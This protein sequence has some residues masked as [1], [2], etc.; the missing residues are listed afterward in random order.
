MTDYIIAVCKYVYSTILCTQI[1]EHLY[2]LGEYITT[3]SNL[4]SFN[5]VSSGALFSFIVLK[6]SWISIN[7]PEVQ[8]CKILHRSP[9]F[10]MNCSSSTTSFR[11][12]IIVVEIETDR[13]VE[14]VFERRK[15]RMIELSFSNDELFCYYQNVCIYIFTTLSH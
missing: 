14:T 5:I 4:L 2:F 11:C 10:H 9:T 12:E 13:Q 6:V 7:N 3:N 8:E 1:K 15:Q